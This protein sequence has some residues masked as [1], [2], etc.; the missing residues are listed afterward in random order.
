MVKLHPGFQDRFQKIVSEIAAQEGAKV[1]IA[2]DSLWDLIRLSSLVI[3]AVSSVC[4]EALIL[5]KPVISIDVNDRT[6]LTGL[7]QDGL[8][9][10]A[11]DEDGIRRSIASCLEVAERTGA[12]IDRTKPQ[13]VPFVYSADGHASQRVAELIETESAKAV[14]AQGA[15][16]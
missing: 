6:D 4:V 16:E 11:Y 7:V 13:L 14:A 15:Q 12:P 9:I 8:A 2:K 1:V 3:V 10:G 5:G